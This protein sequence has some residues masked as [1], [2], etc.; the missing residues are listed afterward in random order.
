M[1]LGIG[2]L[3][4]A[5]RVEKSVK[6]YCLKTALLDTLVL[7]PSQNCRLYAIPQEAEEPGDPERG[8]S[9]PGGGRDGG[10]ENTKTKT[11]IAGVRIVPATVRAAD[12][13]TTDVVRTTAQNDKRPQ[14]P[15]LRFARNRVRQGVDEVA[16][17]H[18]N[19]K[20]GRRAIGPLDQVAPLLGVR[21]AMNQM[22][23]KG[24]FPAAGI[25]HQRHP[26]IPRGRL[27]RGQGRRLALFPSDPRCFQA[28]DVLPFLRFGCRGV[29]ID[30]DVR[31]PQGVFKGARI[32]GPPVNAAQGD[33]RAGPG[34]E[35]PVNAAITSNCSMMASR[36]SLRSGL[37]GACS[38]AQ[39]WTSPSSA[40]SFHFPN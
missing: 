9:E 4:V 16:E 1:A 6:K 27:Q 36:A 33:V 38:A 20:E 31:E 28:I 37:F 34:Q 14:M 15:R 8:D 30:I 26:F 11:V 21:Q 5:D 17:D 25:P 19:G 13:C 18:E 22:A 23:D 3:P 39:S 32:A 40:R 29:Q 24:R 7:L 35:L 2:I 12:A 10:D